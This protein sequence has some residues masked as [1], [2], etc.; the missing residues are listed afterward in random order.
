MNELLVF[1]VYEVSM[2]LKQVVESQIE[3]LYVQVK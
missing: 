2:H 3:E 1:S